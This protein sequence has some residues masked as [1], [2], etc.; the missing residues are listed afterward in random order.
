MFHKISR[1]CLILLRGALSLRQLRI[2]RNAQPPSLRALRNNLLRNHF[3]I[4]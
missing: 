4:L 2:V 3:P 1:V